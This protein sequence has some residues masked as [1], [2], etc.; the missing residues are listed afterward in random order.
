MFFF[1]DPSAGNRLIAKGLRERG[2]L[3]YF[4]PSKLVSNADYEAV[5]VSDIIKFSDENIS[6]RSIRRYLG[7][8]GSH[9]LSPQKRWRL[10]PTKRSPGDN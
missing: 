1:D 10:W 7:M 3:I 6:L 5:A 4:E 8:M 9:F 2:S